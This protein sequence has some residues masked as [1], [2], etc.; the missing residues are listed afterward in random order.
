MQCSRLES[1]SRVST[2][3][4]TFKAPGLFVRWYTTL[5][6]SP[7]VHS[8]VLAPVQG[9]LVYE[10]LATWRRMNGFDR[11]VEGEEN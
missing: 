7:L 4:F 8:E 11:V 6:S 2:L 10:K 3:A 5:F 1:C 9:F